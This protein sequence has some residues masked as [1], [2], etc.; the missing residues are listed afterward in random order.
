MILSMEIFLFLYMVMGQFIIIYY[1]VTV[2]TKVT[3]VT[4]HL[5][6]GYRPGL[7]DVS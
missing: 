2:T 7:N 3:V 6:T 5:L 1:S 4:S